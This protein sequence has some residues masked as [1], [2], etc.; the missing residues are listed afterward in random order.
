MAPTAA[1]PEQEVFLEPVASEGPDPFTE[2]TSEATGTP[3][4]V[5]RTPEP[6]VTG[7]TESQHGARVIS[8]GTPGLYGGTRDKASCDV[9]AQI[10]FLGAN[11]DKQ[12]AFA[13]TIGAA[14]D[15]VPGYLRGLT[16]VQLR[17]DTRVT[18]HGY[19]DGRADAR[20]SVLQAGTAVLVDNRGVPRV[21]CSCGNPL[22]PPGAVQSNPTYRGKKWS[23]Y[24]PS[25]VVVVTPAPTVITNIVIINI[26]NNT[27][28]ERPT[29]HKGKD[30]V[31]PRPKPSPTSPSPTSP[32]PTSP[33][34]TS[35][36]P[37]SPSPTSP[38]PTPTETETET[39]DPTDGPTGEPTD[40]PTDA[41][42]DE[43]TDVPTDAPT[44]EGV[45][46]GATEEVVPDQPAEPGTFNS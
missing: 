36:S 27:W 39:D 34:P 28:I 16:A 10:R 3:P 6:V 5:T 7:P 26:T 22:S 42:T 11:R 2:S 25:K 23:G 33:S 19:V 13:D 40:G 41:P 29:G 31:V 45:P 46:D 21:R 9:E 24:E 20:Q 1:D 8:G 32:S 37:T 17:A 35:P 18:N 38:S 12:Q 14:P 15:R 30:K 4:P 44:D 43:L